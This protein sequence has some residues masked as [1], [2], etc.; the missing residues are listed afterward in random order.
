MRLMSILRGIQNRNLAKLS[1]SIIAKK[2]RKWLPVV[3][4]EIH[5]QLKSHSKLFSSSSNT[6]GASANT[7]VS[8][9]DAAIPGTLPVL[10]QRCV[11]LGVYTALALS[12]KVNPVSCFDR[13]HYFYADLPAGYQITQQRAPLACNGQLEFPVFQPGVH[14][15]PYTKLS[16]IHQMQLEQDSG[17]SLYDSNGRN[18]VDLNRAGVPLIEIVFAPDLSDGYEAAAL[19]KELILILRRIGTCSC[20]MEEGALRVDANVSVHKEGDILGVRTEIKNIGS[21]KGVSHAVN[22]EIKRQIDLLDSGGEI[23]NETRAWDALLDV[24]VP[25]RDKEMKQDYRFM[26]EPN[27]PPLRLDESEN[28]SVSKL[29]QSLPELPAETRQKLAKT[30]NLLPETVIQLVNIEDLF[31]IFNKIMKNDPNRNAKSVASILLVELM[32]LINKGLT[33]FNERK[34]NEDNLGS[35]VDLIHS[36]DINHNIAKVVMDEIANGNNSAP[37]EI[38]TALGLW[39]IKDK[40]KLTRICFKIIKENPSIV[41]QYKNGKTKVFA[42]LLG[43]VASETNNKAKMDVV[44]QL[45]KEMLKD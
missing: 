41:N 34:F 35:I 24:T 26:P 32:T 5:V 42:A 4:L 31:M 23:I 29:K 44:A 33:D 2:R 40:E 1:D 27:L 36:G 45:L 9:F 21:I 18:L 19:V 13:K 3:G 6:F 43:K 11:E 28:I 17:K 16:K 38:I 12:C 8:L 37:K 7:N 10:N 22:Y 20:K 30:F 25:M 15:K 39:Q 14:K